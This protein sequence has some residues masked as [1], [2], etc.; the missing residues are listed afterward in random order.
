M[1]SQSRYSLRAANEFLIQWLVIVLLVNLGIFSIIYFFV[2]P[3]IVSSNNPSLYE[4]LTWSIFVVFMFSLFAIT[5]VGINSSRY[6]IDFNFAERW[7]I[8]R[9]K[10]KKRIEYVDIKDVKIVRMPLLGNALNIGTILLLTEKSGKIK[11]KMRII[12]IKHPQEVYLDILQRS[13]IENSEI[14]GE[15][16]LL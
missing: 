13:N 8:Y 4:K 14:S 11:A 9:P 12:G 7:S 5:Y 2:N 15:D 10:K 6:W 16:L 3:I 1:N